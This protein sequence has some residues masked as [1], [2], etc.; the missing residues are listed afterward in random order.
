MGRR[1]SLREDWV[2]VKTLM[3]LEPF[4]VRFFVGEKFTKI[5]LA[6]QL[7]TENRLKVAQR[8]FLVFL[9]I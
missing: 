4:E 6:F 2:C 7:F 5:G 3:G 9:T 8:L 1:S